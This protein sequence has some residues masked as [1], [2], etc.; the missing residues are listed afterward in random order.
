MDVTFY[1]TAWNIIHKFMLQITKENT[2]PLE[3]DRSTLGELVA[4]NVSIDSSNAQGHLHA[5]I[6][7]AFD[8]GHQRGG[9]RLDYFYIEIARRRRDFKILNHGNQDGLYLKNT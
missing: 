1:H 3:S 7:F 6:L 5:A 4:K 9:G 2:A 8:H